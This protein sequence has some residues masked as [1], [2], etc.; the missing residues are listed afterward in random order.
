MYILG[1][2]RAQSV[3]KWETKEKMHFE[4]QQGHL[5]D[6]CSHASAT[7]PN[8]PRQLG[9]TPPSVH[10]IAP[11]LQT[12]V[13][14]CSRARARPRRL[15]GL[16]SVS[17]DVH[18]VRSKLFPRVAVWRGRLFVVYLHASTWTFP[19]VEET[20]MT[21]HAFPSMSRFSLLTWCTCA[22]FLLAEVE[23]HICLVI[24]SIQWCGTGDGRSSMY[25]WAAFPCTKVGTRRSLSLSQGEKNH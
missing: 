18:R 19:C 9:C 15:L 14:S 3:L 2:F 10:Q 5:V 24:Y 4:L 22:R 1:E 13:T 7:A 12:M 17:R 8:N 11:L 25:D 23:A 16:R 6:I 21:S 20:G